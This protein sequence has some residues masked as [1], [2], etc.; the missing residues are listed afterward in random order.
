MILLKNIYHIFRR[1]C[2]HSKSFYMPPQAQGE[3]DE[4]KIE[5]MI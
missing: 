5:I 4:I 2:N 3:D 1:L